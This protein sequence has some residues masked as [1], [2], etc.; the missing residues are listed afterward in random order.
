MIKLAVGLIFFN[1]VIIII[2]FL[3]FRILYS[4]HLA[5]YFYKT[6]NDTILDLN[7]NID[8]N[9]KLLD[10]RKEEVEELLKEARYQAKK[11]RTILELART[12]QK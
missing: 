3:I 12:N 1:I 11:L 10:Q 5:K 6:I 4:R 7:R 2:S 8:A 9:L